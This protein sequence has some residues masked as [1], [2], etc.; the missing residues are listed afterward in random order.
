MNDVAAHFGEI[1]KTNVFHRTDSIC[2]MLSNKLTALFHFAAKDVADIREIALQ[3]SVDW[4]QA[5]QD[6]RQKEAA[7]N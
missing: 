6:A 7:L 5:I 3:E 1:V 2:N 4:V